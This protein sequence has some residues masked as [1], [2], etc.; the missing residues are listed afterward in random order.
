MSKANKIPKQTEEDKHS[1]EY[2][3]NYYQVPAFPGQRVLYTGDKKKG[4]QP[5][6]IVG[7]VSA[8]IKIRIDGEKDAYPYHPTW[9]LEYV[10]EEG[11]PV[12][13]NPEDESNDMS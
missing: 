12:E 2:V 10:D 11:N 6:V 7:G 9:E 5:G 4:P 1:L 3:R 8:H 13:Y